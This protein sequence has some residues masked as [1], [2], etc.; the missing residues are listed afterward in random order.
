MLTM[1]QQITIQTLHKQGKNKTQI[2]KL[3]GCHR[4]TVRKIL[5]RNDPIEKQTSSKSSMFDP[6]KQHTPERWQ[7][8]ISERSASCP[9][10]A[11]NQSKRTVWQLFFPIRGSDTLPSA[12]TRSWK[13]LLH[14][15]RRRLSTLGVFPGN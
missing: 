10:P 7:K 2:A 1:Y 6:Y 5:N 11:V 12:I 13:H 14:C 15:L 9:D 8:L 3:L 4:H